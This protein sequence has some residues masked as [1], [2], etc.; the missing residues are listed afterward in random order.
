MWA[1]RPKHILLSVCLTDVTDP[2]IKVEPS[3]LYFKAMDCV[4]HAL[5]R[6][7]F[8]FNFYKGKYYNVVSYGK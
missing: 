3:K 1:Q 5:Q 8:L 6:N 7:I 4:L 2:V